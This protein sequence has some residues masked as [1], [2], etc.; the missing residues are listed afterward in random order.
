MPDVFSFVHG[1]DCVPTMSL[2]SLYS[3]FRTIRNV[4]RL[5]LDVYE[6]AEFILDTRVRA[7]RSGLGLD[8]DMGSRERRTIARDILELTDQANSSFCDGNNNNNN[9]LED[10]EQADEEEELGVDNKN[11]NRARV[12]GLAGAREE[13][14]TA[15]LNLEGDLSRFTR[16]A[17]EAA[18]G[19]LDAV[20]KAGDTAESLCESLGRVTDGV[21]G[22][23]P[24]EVAL[25]ALHVKRISD[26]GGGGA[27]PDEMLAMVRRCEEEG[28]S[29]HR[30]RHSD[31]SNSNGGSSNSSS[32]STSNSSASSSTN[33]SG[34]DGVV[35]SVRRT[36]SEELSKGGI[37]LSNRMVDDHSMDLYEPAVIA[38]AQRY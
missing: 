11:K 32:T 9:N 38:A 31:D 36:T 24:E 28:R 25:I 14:L 37:R 12:L 18:E 29:H 15:I 5:P 13:M 4:D 21:V 20:G 33:S 2:G 30:Y 8:A 34:L 3:L 23:T 27:S 10:K 35:F 19:L 26:S 7:R 16:D 1:S 22:M 6:R 17:R